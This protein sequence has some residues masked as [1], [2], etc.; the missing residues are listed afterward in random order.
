MGSREFEGHRV[1]I[2]IQQVTLRRVRDPGGGGFEPVLAIGHRQLEEEQLLVLQPV[3]CG[4]EVIIVSG[5]MDPVQRVRFRDQAVTQLRLQGVLDIGRLLERMEDQVP[6]RPRC[7]A[8]GCRMDRRDPAGVHGVALGAEHFDVE[9]LHLQRA[10]I[11]PDDPGDG[12]LGTDAIA[13]GDPRLIEEGEVKVARP[14]VERDRHHGATV[15]GLPLVDPMHPGDQGRLPADTQLLDGRHARAIDVAPRIVMQELADRSDPECIGEDVGRGRTLLLQP[16]PARRDLRIDRSDR[17]GHRQRHGEPFQGL[18]PTMVAVSAR[19]AIRAAILGL[20][21]AAPM[22]CTSASPPTPPSATP[23]A[24]PARN[25][26]TAPLL[27]TQATALPDI[28]PQTYGE[29]LTQLRG[30]PVVVNMWGSWCGP[31]RVEAPQLAAA[32]ARYGT[33]VQFIGIDLMDTR[34]SAEGFIR[35]AAWS[36]PSFFDPSSA[37]DVRSSLG[38]IGQPVT[39]IYDADGTKVADR[40]GQMPDGWLDAQLQDLAPQG[41]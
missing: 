4:G 35:D 31:C 16:H 2:A 37:G 11:E 29:L 30:T 27:P 18:R 13:G 6:D 33:E 22:A 19:R 34:P 28:T 38:Y 9:V 40:Q 23:S 24:S 3:A 32:A 5:E 25:A 10:L 15:A 26:T 12:H 36:Y 14:V 39:I 20:V 41:S 1:P 8:V 7:D 17:R 21:V